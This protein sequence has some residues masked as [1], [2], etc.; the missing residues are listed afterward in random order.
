MASGTRCIRGWLGVF[1]GVGYTGKREEGSGTGAARMEIT[2]HVL[3]KASR[4]LG[5]PELFGSEAK[6]LHRIVGS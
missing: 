2:T 1:I 4:Q 3:G 6:A 5:S